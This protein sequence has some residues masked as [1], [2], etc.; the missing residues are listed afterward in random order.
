MLSVTK[1]AHKYYVGNLLPTSC[2][3]FSVMSSTLKTS[4]RRVSLNGDCFFTNSITCP[5]SSDKNSDHKV[6]LQHTAK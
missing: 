2:C 1:L 5:M 3:F 4:E 6:M